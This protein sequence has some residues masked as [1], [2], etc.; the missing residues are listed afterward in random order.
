MHPQANPPTTW[1]TRAAEKAGS[2]KA[3]PAARAAAPPKRKVMTQKQ[4][5]SV[6]DWMKKYWRERRRKAW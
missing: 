5:E 6:A 4:R 1:I 3:K 2:R